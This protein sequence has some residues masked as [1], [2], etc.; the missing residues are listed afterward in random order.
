MQRTISYLATGL[1][2]SAL[3]IC[4][5]F[6]FSE[7][8][9]RCFYPEIIPFDD[10]DWSSRHAEYPLEKPENTF[11]IVVLGD[12][13]TF[14]QG[15]KKDLTF[16][17]RLEGFLNDTRGERRFEVINLGFCGLNTERE[18]EIL[19]KRGINPRNWLPDPAYKGLSYKP[20]LVILEYTLN[21]SSRHARAL[22]DIR[23]MDMTLGKRWT[24]RLN[25]GK[26]AIP[27]PEVLDRFLTRNSKFYLFIIDR[28]NRLLRDWGV[29]KEQGGA[30][31]MESRYKEHFVGWKTVKGYL[32][33]F[34]YFSYKTG[35]PV[36]LVIFP[37][38]SDFDNYP[39]RS[40]HRQVVEAARS[41]GLTHVVDLLSSFNGRNPRKLRVSPVDGHPNR[42]AH[43]IA[44]EAIFNYLE[45]ER[46]LSSG[47]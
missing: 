5:V 39:Y 21:D 10:Y 25:N 6:I 30:D 19:V 4:L 14:G 40:I 24:I 16:S 2:L 23:G 22:E 15:V 44:A 12:S 1:L 3:S 28:Y 47:G 26:Y 20:D 32:L 13:F 43:R 11:R 9:V 42:V 46:L 35:I 31:T 27:L 17:K 29:R 18:F 34:G 36:V 37:Q 33:N 45:K 7:L 38:V 41:G 8:L